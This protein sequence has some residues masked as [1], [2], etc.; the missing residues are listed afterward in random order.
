M[1]SRKCEVKSMV[2]EVSLE[3]RGESSYGPGGRGMKSLRSIKFSNPRISR[4][5]CTHI[6]RPTRVSILRVMQDFTVASNNF[7]T[8]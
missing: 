3:Q 8:E 4:V 7:R 1:S 6:V 5:W 2:C